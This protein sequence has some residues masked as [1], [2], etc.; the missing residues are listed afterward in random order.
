MN[1][2]IKK[3]TEE[4]KR[5]VADRWHTP[6]HKGVLWA[7]DL[8][9]VDG[10]R[11]YP[12]DAVIR[13]QKTVA[14]LYGARELRFLTGG[15]SM[16]VKAAVMA[17]GGDILAGANSHRSVFEGA[18]LAGVR[19]VII[20]NA[21]AD[22]LPLPLT[23]SQIERGLAD[24]PSVAAVVLTSPDYFGRVC[25]P[26]A[27]EAV[28]RAGKILI[29]DSAHGAHFALRKDLFP[30]SLA[31]VADFC[32][33]SAHKTMCAMTQGAYLCVNN[34]SLIEKADRALRL[35]GTTSPL[36]PL[37]DSLENAA[38]IG[39]YKSGA[40]DALK[41]L[42]DNFKTL[43]PTLGND[44]FSRVVVDA[45]RLNT[46]GKTLFDKL[47]SRGVAAETY[48]DGYVVFIATPFDDG[49]KFARLADAILKR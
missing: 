35:L 7:D 12:G 47:L 10:G 1:T 46:D 21:V 42:V 2:D 4:Y 17:A 49:A 22:G 40:Y 26:S 11:R 37:L 29:A 20:Q 31:S 30:K 36:Y 6:G 44:D 23:A 14:E 8:T 34:G 45:R 28:R 41:T 27:V 19:A 33:M 24:N 9:E 5:G 18:E 43:V 15:S 38:Y 3:Q 13:A 39:F 32:N 25:A 48:T 16:G